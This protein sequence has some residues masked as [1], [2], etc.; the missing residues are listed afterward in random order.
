MKKQSNQ[1]L[2][3]NYTIKKG[4]LP[5]WNIGDLKLW[6]QRIDGEVQIAYDHAS[7]NGS[8]LDSNKP[9]KDISWSRWSVKNDISSIQLVP[10][11][12]DRAVVIKP[13][14]SFKIIK[15]EHVRIYARVPTW[16]QINAVNKEIIHLIDIP[17]VILSNT[18][19]GNFREGELCYWISSGLRQHIE[20]DPSR[21]YMAICPIVIINKSHEELLIEEICLRV[22]NLSLYIDNNQLWS[23][24]TKMVYKGDDQISYIS[25]SGNPP[26]ESPDAVLLTAPRTPIKK[27]F[28]A[29]TFMS[30]KDL[31][32]LSVPAE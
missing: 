32:G 1:H 12:P 27:S 6:C 29:K 7:G 30:L 13:E 20:I 25:V 15:N 3:Q 9:D 10:L 14:S 16:I 5:Y 24:E 18:W 4:D 21:N 23:D 22:R 8:L 26:E 19:F 31:P 17:S 2:W 28:I 11:F